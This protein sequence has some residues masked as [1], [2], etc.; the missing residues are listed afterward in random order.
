MTPH[1]AAGFQD[2]HAGAELTPDEVEFAL[3]MERYKR[4]RRRP[5]P[6]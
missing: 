5:F 1:A 2:T 4:L 3:A 6:T